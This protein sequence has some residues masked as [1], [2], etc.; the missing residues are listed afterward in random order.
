ME[1][2]KSSRLSHSFVVRLPLTSFSG[3]ISKHPNMKQTFKN[4]WYHLFQAHWDILSEHK[5]ESNSC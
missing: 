2:L 4:L 5:N 3:K 1:K